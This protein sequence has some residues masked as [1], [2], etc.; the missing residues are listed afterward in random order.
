MLQ[1]VEPVTEGDRLLAVD[2]INRQRMNPD[3]PEDERLAARQQALLLAGA[4]IGQG[5]ELLAQQ[6]RT[7]LQTAQRNRTGGRCFRQTPVLGAGLRNGNPDRPLQR[8]HPGLVALSRHR[9]D[10]VP[11][12]RNLHLRPGDESTLEHGAVAG[13]AQIELDGLLRNLH[14]LLVLIV[15]RNDQMNDVLSAFPLTMKGH[16]IDLDVSEETHATAV[17]FGFRRL[18]GQFQRN[19]VEFVRCCQCDLDVFILTILKRQ[20][21][22]GREVTPAVAELQ[23]GAV[24]FH[25]DLVEF[26]VGLLIGGSIREDI[27][28]GLSVSDLP[29]TRHKVIAVTK[30]GPPGFL[31]HFLQRATLIGLIQILGRELPADTTTANKSRD[32]RGFI[33][34]WI[35]SNG[36]Q[37]TNV[38]D[39]ERYS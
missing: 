9:L 19:L 23:S 13:F 11:A 27:V 4:Q 31:G 2:P 28:E 29:E 20:L 35:K 7:A 14:L 24:H 21:L 36:I 8:S 37:T 6:Q 34:T 1:V 12:G 22:P 18:I 25:P 3:V 17:L 32:H 30:I 33:A 16:S 26:A 39:V 10:R 5:G 15:Y 38:Y